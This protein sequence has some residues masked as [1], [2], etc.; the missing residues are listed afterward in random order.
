MDLF[1]LVVEV[2]LVKCDFVFS[3]VFLYYDIFSGVNEFVCKLLKCFC[4][5]WVLE[6]DRYKMNNYVL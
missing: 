5:K 1:D 6:C 3:I 4:E 2:E